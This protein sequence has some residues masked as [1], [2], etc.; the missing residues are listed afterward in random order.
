MP[1][2]K[3]ACVFAHDPDEILSGILWDSGWKIERLDVVAPLRKISLPKDCSIG[4]L[5]LTSK[6]PA[7]FG[8]LLTIVAHLKNLNWI[9]VVDRALV[10]DQ[11]IR[12]FIAVHCV[13]YQTLP[14][15]RDRV[16]F[17]LGH[18]AGMA[19]ITGETC[20]DARAAEVAANLF[21][22]TPVMRALRSDLSKIATVDAPVLI[23]GESG[24]GKEL[25]AHAIHEMSSRR[26]QPFV[27][28]NCVSLPPSLIHAE[29]FGFER[30]AFTGAN[31][32][33][34][35]HFESAHRGTI[36]LDEIGDLHQE[37][38]A[39][40]LRFLEEQVV[41]RV[42]GREEIRVDARVVAATNVDLESAIKSGTFRSDLYYRL[43]ILRV[44]TPPLRDRRED[45]EPLARMFLKRFSGENPRR[46]RGFSE[47]ALAAMYRHDWPGNVRELLNRVRRAIVMCE[48][49]L[50]T[51]GD[52][53]FSV[54]HRPLDLSL[55][56]AR[57][58]AE[59][60]TILTAL[61]CS[62]GNAG[63]SAQM[64]GVSRATFYRL[65][66]KHGVALNERTAFKI[67]PQLLNEGAS[68]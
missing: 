3:V 66:E 34:V 53:N 5:V 12:E 42:G 56:T 65:L 33:K 45:I 19:A 58:E 11:E 39:L 23:T 35:G 48:G 61:Q 25:V 4:I 26:D 50:I 21:G 29:L 27:A 64:V 31:H 7:W 13:D 55:E 47:S 57:V 16:L 24:T 14:L 1:N 10:R 8:K 32:R 28:I 60:K 22:D 30:G 20:E 68:D 38:Q 17:A 43:N 44:R 40:L 63:K 15:D 51:P 59:R 62:G 9:A 41:R 67:G 37:L 46:P 36:L 6:E 49:R 18:L 2:K 54:D 52:L